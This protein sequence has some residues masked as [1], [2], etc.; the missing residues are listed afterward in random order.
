MTKK[1]NFMTS[2]FFIAP[3]A[4]LSSYAMFA[5]ALGPSLLG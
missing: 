4:I 2:R 1:D 3:L 5:A